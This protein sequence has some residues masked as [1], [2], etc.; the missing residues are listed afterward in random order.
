M[1]C[2]EALEP[3]RLMAA[4][5]LDAMFGTGGVVDV[6]ADAR[7]GLVEV[8]PDEK[9]LTVHQQHNPTLE[10]N[11]V[12]IARRFLSNGTPDTTFGADGAARFERIEG[13]PYLATEIAALENGKVLIA[14]VDGGG[15]DTVLLNV[16]RLNSDGTLDT[17]FGGPAR[18]HGT[19]VAGIAS[20]PFANPGSGGYAA[21]IAIAPDGRIAIVGHVRTAG[22]AAMLTPDGSL[23]TTFSGDGKVIWG[24]TAGIE[25]AM[26]LA[27]S[28]VFQPN[29]TLVV[30]GTKSTLIDGVGSREWVISAFTPSG[31][32][33]TFNAVGPSYGGLSDLAALPNGSVLAAGWDRGNLVMARYRAD[34]Q[35]DSSFGADG[36]SFTPA[37]Q[38]VVPGVRGLFLPWRIAMLADGRFYLLARQQEIGVGEEIYLSRYLADGTHDPSFAHH[39]PVEPTPGEYLSHDFA[40]SG[41]AALVLTTRNRGGDV[42]DLEI[43]RFS[44]AGPR[45]TRNGTLLIGGTSG[46]DAIAMTRRFRDGRILAEVNGEARLYLPQLVKRIQVYGFGGDDVITVGSDV[47][48]AFIHG[49][50]GND[51]LT[52]GD[53]DDLLFGGDGDDVL[54]GELGSDSLEGGLGND[55]LFG[56]AGNDYLLGSAGHDTIHGYGGRDILIGAGGND[57]LFGGPGWADVISGGPGFDSAAYDPLDH[58][59]GIEQ[60]RE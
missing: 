15:V 44:A 27:S 53:G 58:Y 46:D 23:D 18:G 54:T 8:L 16:I 31:E 56:N 3:R 13:L 32:P 21:D 50:D 43:R 11:D 47:R 55:L 14:G 20:V 33:A 35:A 49:G 6:A 37:P 24:D 17:S 38:P 42:R 22:V 48:S 1:N 60:P 4:G 19:V 26:L 7:S 12:L 57:Q 30:G 29:G 40:V 52:G 2:A 45:L 28:A 5:E 41:D 9:I 51:T 36:F 10:G 25:V 39:A 59:A 34:G